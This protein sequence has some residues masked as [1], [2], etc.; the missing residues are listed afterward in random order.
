MKSLSSGPLDMR[1]VFLATMLIS[2]FWELS[3]TSGGWLQH[4]IMSLGSSM[5][6]VAL[7]YLYDFFMAARGKNS[8]YMNE[9]YSGTKKDIAICSILGLTLL[10]IFY[11]A[12]ASYSFTSIDLAGLGLPFIL[13]SLADAI[14]FR[15]IKVANLSLPKPALWFIFSLLI[16]AYIGSAYF[17]YQIVSNNYTASQ[18]LWLQITILS[19]SIYSFFAA[20]FIRFA[21][22]KQRLEP[23]P[24]L[25]DLLPKNRFTLGLYAETAKMTEI[26]NAEVEKRKAAI[27]KE[28]QKKS[29]K[30][31]KR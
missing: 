23:S 9:F 2:F 15:K 12:P 16:G 4:W 21:L 24:V 7:I 29:K 5:W 20:A 11:F 14:S 17:L 6:G 31:G 10:A 26:W 25:L 28:K 3:F 22:E 13:C 18:A 19:G 1:Y 8:P 30:K 27:R